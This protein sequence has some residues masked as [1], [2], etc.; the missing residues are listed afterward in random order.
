MELFTSMANMLS[1]GL[2]LSF[3]FVVTNA[4]APPYTK[5]TLLINWMEGL[6]SHGISPEFTH[7]DKDQ[8]EINTLNQV[9][10]TVKHQLCLWHMLHALKCR[11][12]NNWEPLAFYGSAYAKKIFAFID[13]TFVPLWQMS[14]KDKVYIHTSCIW[15]AT[16]T[17][18][19]QPSNPPL[20]SPNTQ[21]SSS[22][23]PVPQS[24][25]RLLPWISMPKVWMDPCHHLKFWMR[26]LLFPLS[27][28]GT[29]QVKMNLVK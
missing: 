20:K 18:C 8:L 4:E 7:S 27:N 15:P 2:P 3:L 19:R 6:K 25:Q 10:P 13:P 1:K 5:E 11:L 9:W 24:I 29:L 21:S 28:I 22:S 23:K 26:G 14:A 16:L 17:Y 12:A